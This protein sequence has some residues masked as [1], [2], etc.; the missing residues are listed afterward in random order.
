LGVDQVIGCPRH[1]MGVHEWKSFS[2]STK[3]AQTTFKAG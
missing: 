2:H 3:V 1:R